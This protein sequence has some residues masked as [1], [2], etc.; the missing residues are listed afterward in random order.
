MHLARLTR[1]TAALLAVLLLAAGSARAEPGGFERYHPDQRYR[2]LGLEAM[3]RGEHE[4]ALRWFRKAARFAD[5]ASQAMVAEMFWDGIGTAVDKARAYAWMDLAAERHYRSFLVKREHYWNALDAAARERALDI[6]AQV[7]AE[8]GDAVAKP[9]LEAQLR[10]G[11]RASTGSRLGARGNLRV[12]TAGPGGSLSWQPDYYA[13]RHWEPE[14]YWQEQDRIW[15]NPL[16]GTVRV[17]PLQPTFPV[18]ERRGPSP[19]DLPVPTPP[20]D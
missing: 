9:R 1:F 19:S 16:R 13:A 20:A 17:D 7:Y 10:R 8:F 4:W 12:Y 5:K 15:K 3:E 18:P 11:S 2:R 14:A 6:G